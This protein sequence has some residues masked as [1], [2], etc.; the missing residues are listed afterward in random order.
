[1]DISIL[2]KLKIDKHTNVAVINAPE[3]FTGILKDYKGSVTGK[4]KGKYSYVQVFITSQ[5]EFVKS[6]K[7]LSNAI[8][9][10]GLLWVC[11]PKGTSKKYKKVDCNRDT[12][13]EAIIPYGFEGVSII[14]LDEDWS[15]LRFRNSEF[16]GK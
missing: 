5:S 6:G 16:V 7:L 1:M 11:Y 8:E 12:L 13:R 4:I 2:K 14:S 3:E 10:D 15:A 9:G